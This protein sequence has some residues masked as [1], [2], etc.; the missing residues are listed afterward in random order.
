MSRS[1]DPAYALR[2]LGLGLEF[3]VAFTGHPVV[4]RAETLLKPAAAHDLHHVDHQGCDHHDGYNDGHD[5]P[6]DMA[7][8]NGPAGSG[9]AA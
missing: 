7:R 6:V 4:F 2:Q 8:L 5:D 1:P 9:V 3:A